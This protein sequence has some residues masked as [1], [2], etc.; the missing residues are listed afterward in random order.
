MRKFSLY[1]FSAL[2]LTSLLGASCKDEDLF[3]EPGATAPQLGGIRISAS[4]EEA[5]SSRAYI[6]EGEVT[7]GTYTLYYPYYIQ[8]QDGTSAYGK[9]HFLF[10]YGEVKFGYA[11]QEATGFVNVGSDTNPRELIWSTTNTGTS[12]DD[13]IIYYPGVK[14]PTPVY[15]DN[16]PFFRRTTGTSFTPSTEQRAD[17]IMSLANLP[18]GNPF[19]PGI[20]DFDNGSNDLLWG[21]GTTLHGSDRIQIPMSHRMTRFVLNVNVDNT[22]GTGMNID[23]KDA[24][25]YIEGLLLDPLT[26]LRL[27]GELRFEKKMGTE[28][29][30]YLAS[31]IDETLYNTRVYLKGKP[32]ENFEDQPAPGVQVLCSDDEGG[33]QWGDA[34]EGIVNEVQTYTTQ[35][36]VFVP[37]ELRQGSLTRPRLVIAVPAGDVNSGINNG[38]ENQNYI[39][40]RGGLPYTMNVTDTDGTTAMMTLNFMPGQVLT[41]TTQMKPGALELEFAPVTVEPWVY[42]GTFGPNAKQSGIFNGDEFVAMVKCY[43][44]NDTFGLRKYGYIKEGETTWN[45]MFNQGNQKIPVFDVVGKMKQ[46]E[47]AINGGT[48]V[49]PPYVFDFR[50]RDQYYLMPNGQEKLM[51]V[52]VLNSIVTADPNEGVSDPSGFAELISAYQNNTWEM[53]KYGEYVKY[54][55]SSGS[56]A[57]PGKWTFKIEGD[58]T[59][60]ATTIAAQMIPPVATDSNF[61][62]VIEGSG[63]VSVSNYPST[64]E[65]TQVD[66][67]TLYTIVTT[68]IPGIYS[69]AEFNAVVAALNAGNTDALD[70]Y[71]YQPAGGTAWVFPLQRSIILNTKSLQGVIANTTI[72]FS[73][74]LNGQKIDLQQYN[75]SFVNP[76]AD[77]VKLIMTLNRMIGIADSTAFNALIES[78]NDGGDTAKQLSYYGYYN[79]TG[80]SWTFI[81]QDTM[82]LQKDLIEK[83]MVPESPDKLDYSFDLNFKIINLVED[84]PENPTELFGNQGAKQLY[85]VT[86]G[87]V[88]EEE[89]E[90]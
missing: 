56:H 86:S 71:G 78:Y 28:Q 62:F 4:I 69:T 57:E 36:F 39:Y 19:K 84:N 16:M 22:E 61:E 34:P 76:T 44:E 72:D 11:G 51:V 50:S 83:Q 55:E 24:I 32:G 23:L 81:F 3:P 15:L 26:Y 68:R 53:F 31:E 20:F 48:G 59:L 1:I 74:D 33:W 35:D 18:D 6:R 80:P 40:Y 70:E 43:Q 29:N 42:K 60:D 73:F 79:V 14:D 82:T 46:G 37:Q 88:E 66:D 41:I 87:N 64:G 47:P 89:V 67:A 77:D 63:T 12:A 8:W 30:P 45:F 65:T 75:A 25:V 9:F 10:N 27:Y 85:E 21:K 54:D 90:P 2:A 52:S 5:L 49:T 7:S 17:S 58:I 38:Y 13:G